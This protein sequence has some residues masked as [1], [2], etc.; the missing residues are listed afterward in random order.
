MHMSRDYEQTGV[1]PHYLFNNIQGSMDEEVGKMGLVFFVWVWLR[2]IRFEARLKFCFKQ[3]SVL[4]TNNHKQKH[5]CGKNRLK[6]S[7]GKSGGPVSAALG[8]FG[9]TRLSTCFRTPILSS[10]ILTMEVD[11]APFGNTEDRIKRIRERMG[12]QQ[13]LVEVLPSRLSSNNHPF[14]HFSL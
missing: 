2:A 3:R 14:P 5:D 8:E 1:L 12:T 7:D 11:T 6:S 4:L 13:L 10:S 9:R